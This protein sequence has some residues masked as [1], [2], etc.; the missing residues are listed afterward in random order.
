[1]T[2]TEHLGTDDL[3]NMILNVFNNIN[4]GA[5]VNNQDI[6]YIL[7]KL[8]NKRIIICGAGTCGRSIYDSLKTLGIEVDSIIDKNY[9]IIKKIHNHKVESP[10]KLRMLSY[11]QGKY[12][13]IIASNTLQTSL[14]IKNEI[15]SFFD[16]GFNQILG[17][18]LSR[19]LSYQTCVNEPTISISKCMNCR[20]TPTK[21]AVFRNYFSQTSKHPAFPDNTKSK[22]NDISYLITTNCTLNCKHCV[23]RLPLLQHRKNVD[24]KIFFKDVSRILSSCNFVYR[25]ALT[26][27]EPFLHNG[28]HEMIDFL[29]ESDRVGAI[30]IYTTGTWIPSDKTLRI[31]KNSR[32]AINVSNYG[33]L[34]PEK[35][36][37]NFDTFCDILEKEEIAYNNY[38]C[39]SWFNMGN[40]SNNK[41][42]EQRLIN[43]F[44][45]CPFSACMT[46]YEGILYR[47]PHQLAGALT[48]KLTNKTRDC[49]NINNFGKQKLAAKLDRFV[50]L[51]SIDA[52]RYCTIPAHP[53]ELLAGEQ[54]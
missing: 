49:V 39:K 20:D 40:F 28:I 35:L 43:A 33:D 50:E 24:T 10:T 3:N 41:L 14:F 54:M 52:C 11:D 34:I 2:C 48:G 42:N 18:Y 17:I 32:I 31:L 37:Q 45:N 4:I 38:P 9:S 22:L 16:T 30:F 1:M 23:E 5:Q 51:K 44:E 29:L 8:A 21:C 46:I 47:C 53:K 15:S 13:F 25:V 7:Y 6:E 26:G 12:V 36:K 19:I 27:G